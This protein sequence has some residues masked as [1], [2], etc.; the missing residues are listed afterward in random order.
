M[1]VGIDN[2]ARPVVVTDDSVWATASLGVYDNVPPTPNPARI[3]SITAHKFGQDWWHHITA[4]VATDAGGVEYQFACE[5]NGLLGS[6]QDQWFY[7]AADGSNLPNKSITQG[8]NI[9]I[10]GTVV[11]TVQ[12]NEIWV[13]VS[14]VGVN[15][16]Y[17]FSVRYRQHTSP[18]PMGEWSTPV[19][20]DT[21]GLQ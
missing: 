21:V 6:D 4:E 2:V 19:S 13:R 12:P 1:Y 3:A 15:E 16:N 10:S 9:V 18:Q 14:T 7:V 17:K 20:K 5:L 8:T 11:G